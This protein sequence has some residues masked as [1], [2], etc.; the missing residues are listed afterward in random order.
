M[1]RKIAGEAKVIS[2]SPGGARPQAPRRA[3]LP[4]VDLP[5][6]DRDGPLIDRSGIPGLDSCKIGFAGLVSGARAPAMALEEICRR[7]Q[8]A[9]RGIETSGAV[10]QDVLGQELGMADLAVHGAAGARR[11][12]YAIDQ[13]Q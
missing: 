4:A 11:E 9:A 6:D 2:V 1:L 7:A 10:G 8:R 3:T 12:G 13:C 5:A